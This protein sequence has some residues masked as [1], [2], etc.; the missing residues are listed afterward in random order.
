MAG[1]LT[2]PIIRQPSHPD[3]DRDSGKRMPVILTC[4]G[5]GSQQRVLSG[6]FTRFPIIS[7]FMIKKQERHHSYKDN[8]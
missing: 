3:I 2:C 1:F 8:F 7:V 5:Q 6:N 4:L